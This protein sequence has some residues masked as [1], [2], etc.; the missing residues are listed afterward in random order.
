MAPYFRDSLRVIHRPSGHI[1]VEGQDYICTHFF[2][3]A[4]FNTANALYGSITLL[5]K[6][7]TGLLELN[8]QTLGG[9]WI[10]DDSKILDI[11]SNSLMNPRIVT[12]E[13]VAELPYAFPPI[14][15]KWDLENL[16]N[17]DDVVDVLNDIAIQ[18]QQTSDL[19]ITDHIQNTSNPHQV[20]KAQVGLG[21]V[22]NFGISSL[23]EA[24]E[25]TSNFSFMTPLRTKQLIDNTAGVNLTSHIQDTTNPH[26]V[27]KTQVGLGNVEN[28]PIATQQ[29]AEEGLRN[30]RYITPLRVK[31]VINKITSD[32]INPHIQ[33]IANPHQ[34]TKAQVG[35]GN[36]QNFSIATL[37]DVEESL[38]NTLYMTPLR[39][40]QMISYLVKDYFDLHVVNYTNPHQV[41]KVQVGLGSVENFPIATQQE[42]E[43]GLRN[44][45]Y[46]SPLGVKNSIT[47]E[48][49]RLQGNVDLIA[50]VSLQH[51]NDFDNPH[52]VSAEQLNV[53]TTS[54]VDSFL[55]F[56][57]DITGTVNNAL[58]LDGYTLTE[59]DNY[60]NKI[61]SGLISS[62]GTV[63]TTE[64]YSLIGF[65]EVKYFDKPN[66]CA[67]CLISGFNSY[68]N[69]IRGRD[70][71]VLLNLSLVGTQSSEAIIM[72]GD[73][74]GSVFYYRSLTREV[75]QDFI[76]ENKDIV[77][78]WVK[79]TG[80]RND[81]TAIS[82]DQENPVWFTLT[83]P[84]VMEQP[85]GLIEIAYTKYIKDI[86]IAVINGGT[87]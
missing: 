14:D 30:D 20:T 6:N 83:E 84:T 24:V 64:T 12:W 15:H 43:E 85:N 11:L 53:Y 62:V 50:D 81:I 35:L 38:S 10:L 42:A 57:A 82:I 51:V 23:I 9:E 69:F 66:T 65:V 45:R 67:R 17:M 71:V 29:E 5:D 36:V 60:V 16:R 61:K 76:F 56:K 78:I 48:A 4:T 3:D 47:V 22:P 40:N 49:D 79:Q 39:T 54:Q 68:E 70:A 52:Q 2:H 26:Q 31:D 25:G 74:S 41:T 72:D 32:L 37:T 87:F 44:D 63:E 59:L 34:V 46:M 19:S 80:S 18:I 75:Q 27:T 8:Y 33:N 1:L 86:D 73:V 77:E 28:F 7:L 21:N 13:Q 55:Q 58:N